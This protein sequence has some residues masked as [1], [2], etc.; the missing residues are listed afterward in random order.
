VVKASVA[1]AV[2]YFRLLRN[3]EPPAGADDKDV[4]KVEVPA[5]AG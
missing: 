3:L 5:P 2:D 1:E 4:D